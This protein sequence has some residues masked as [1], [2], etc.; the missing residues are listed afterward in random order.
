M[1]KNASIAVQGFG[2]VGRTIAKLL[3]NEGF[4]VIAVSDIKSGVCSEEGID[5]EGLVKH[6]EDTGFVAGFP[7]TVKIV[8]EF[9]ISKKY[10]NF[11]NYSIIYLK[12]ANLFIKRKIFI[13]NDFCFDCQEKIKMELREV[14]K[15]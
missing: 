2:D 1:T 5:I 6:V 11:K 7:R 14:I 12:T 3:F 13:V 9:S 15:I 8:L 10:N 4:K